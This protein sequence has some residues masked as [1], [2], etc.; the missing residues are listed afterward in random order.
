MSEAEPRGQLCKNCRERIVNSY[1]VSG[2]FP[3]RFSVSVE[4]RCRR[5]L[6]TK[7]VIWLIL[8]A[9]CTC[10][11][12]LQSCFDAVHHQNNGKRTSVSVFDYALTACEIT[13]PL[14]LSD[15]YYHMLQWYSI[16]CTKVNAL[17]R[18]IWNNSVVAYV[19]DLVASVAV[20]S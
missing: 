11:D 2:K 20:C 5:E 10:M 16:A 19:N 17:I 8:F 7:T 15:F 14:G 4:W 18:K 1:C 13:S 9:R 3:T 6:A 12:Y